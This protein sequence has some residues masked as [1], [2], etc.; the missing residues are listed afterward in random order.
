MLLSL[1]S[2]KPSVEQRTWMS[3]FRRL[4]SLGR[5]IRFTWIIV[6]KSLCR[7]CH[8][9]LKVYHKLKN[10][11]WGILSEDIVHWRILIEKFSSPGRRIIGVFWP[12]ILRIPRRAC[13][14]ACVRN[15]M[16]VFFMQRTE[17]AANGILLPSTNGWPFHW[18][19]LD[20]N[21]LETRIVCVH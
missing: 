7:D 4:F 12:T 21:Q 19:P 18:T 11:Q 1:F 2:K 10:P 15:W 13:Q 8:R 3:F 20:A 17:F 6:H 16:P 9:K 5:M 14:V